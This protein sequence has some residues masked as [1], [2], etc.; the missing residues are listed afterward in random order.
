MSTFRFNS[1]NVFLTYPQCPAEKLD[2][3][4][5]LQTTFPIKDWIITKEAHE[6]GSPHLHVVLQFNRKVNKRNADCFDYPV[7]DRTYHPNI[8]TPRKINDCIEYCKKD[9]DYLA[10][11]GIGKAKNDGWGEIRANSTNAAEYLA[12]VDARYPKD[13][14][15]NYERLKVFADIHYVE[16]KEEYL[17]PFQPSDFNITIPEMYNFGVDVID[18][19]KQNPQVRSAWVATLPR[20]RREKDLGAWSCQPTAH[21]APGYAPPLSPPGAQ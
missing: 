4:A 7:E 14:A 3:L 1:R 9:G 12:A 13:Y 8:Q 18:C 15:L 21:T 19:P 20:L 5:W 11:D 2:L 17:S 16:H 10:S 6:D